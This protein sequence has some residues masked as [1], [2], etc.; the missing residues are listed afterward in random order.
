M[1]LTA[2]ARRVIYLIMAVAGL[3]VGT[4]TAVY[5][6]IGEQPT[7]LRV[8]IAGYAYLAGSSGIIAM[9]NTPTAA[10]A[11]PDPATVVVSAEDVTITQD[12]QP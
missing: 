10:V 11:S 3:A 1:I 8:V 12:D 4:L 5:G 6:E 7:W 2:R 9:L